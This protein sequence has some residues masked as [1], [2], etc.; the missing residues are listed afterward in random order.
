MQYKLEC[1]VKISL[2]NNWFF[3]TEMP[4]ILV[5]IFT[6]YKE[7][8]TYS[9]LVMNKHYLPE[10]TKRYWC[11]S[12]ILKN[13]YDSVCIEL[14]KLSLKIKQIENIDLDIDDIMNHFKILIN[15]SKPDSLFHYKIEK[16]IEIE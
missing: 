15:S 1:D 9:A 6:P 10:C 16:T 12:N 13:D 5:T 14:K 7:I 8:H 2:Y 11:D 4:Y 3:D